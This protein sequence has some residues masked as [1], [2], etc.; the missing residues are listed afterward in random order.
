[1]N[2]KEFVEAFY[3]EK[4]DFIEDYMS[5]DSKSSVAAFIKQLNLDSEQQQVLKKILDVSFTDIFY[6]IL[7]GIDGAASIGGVQEMYDLKDESGNQLSGNGEIESQAYDFF[8][9]KK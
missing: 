1:M 8:H 6:T 2:T 4:Q 5:N 3:N 7:L 9:N